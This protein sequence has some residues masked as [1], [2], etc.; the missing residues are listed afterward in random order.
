[1]QEVAPS[2]P[3]ANNGFQ[4]GDII[5]SANNRNVSQPSEVEEEWAKSR[6]RDKPVLFRVT[7]QGQQLFI[8][9]ADS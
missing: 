1:V 8:A 5:V 6:Q 7:R 4:A 2:S 3:A 9:V